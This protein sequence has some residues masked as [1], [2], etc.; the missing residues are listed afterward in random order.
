MW[1]LDGPLVSVVIPTYNR[2]EYLR[3]AIRSVNGQTYRSIEIIVSDDSTED[4]TERFFQDEFRSEFP[5]RYRRNVPSYGAARNF[6]VAVAEAQ[7]EYVNLLMDDDLFAP[8]KIARM[9]DIAESHPGVTLVTST[10][11][12]IDEHDRVTGKALGLESIFDRNTIVE[13]K[14]LAAFLGV[15]VV[16][17]VGEP[18]T[19]LFRRSALD[20]PFGTF[21]GRDAKCNVDLASW[22]NLMLKGDVAYLH[23]PL[24]CLRVHSGQQSAGVE[25]WINGLEDFI[26]LVEQLYRRLGI[27]SESQLDEALVRLQGLYESIAQRMTDLGASGDHLERLLRAGE[28]LRSRF[29]RVENYQSA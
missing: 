5:V 19:A 15:H 28:C 10:R 12:I 7:G 14:E 29:V 8:D 23:A 26:D 16:N 22:T 24:S 9:V 1:R 27:L 6:Q 3:R 13:G 21:G 17:L 18:T 4:E 25:M 11:A 20:E 2:V